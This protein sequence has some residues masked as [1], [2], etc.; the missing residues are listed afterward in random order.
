VLLVFNRMGV[1]SLW[2][3]LLIRAG[4]WFLVLKSGVHATVAGVALAVVSKDVVL[5]AADR[6]FAVEG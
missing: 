6:W 4:L 2:P 1:R 3:Y 5:E